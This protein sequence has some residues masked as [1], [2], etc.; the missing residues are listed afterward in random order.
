[1]LSQLLEWC[2]AKQHAGATQ[3]IRRA[4]ALQIDAGISAPWQ[5]ALEVRDTGDGRGR[6]VFALRAFGRDDIVEVCPVVLA[7]GSL[8]EPLSQRVFDWR[9]LARS[10]HD[11]AL[12]LGFGSLYNHNDDANCRYF[13]ERDHL[14]ICA[15]RGIAPSAELT[16]NYN[17]RGGGPA[18]PRNKWFEG[19]DIQKI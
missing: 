6:G 8:P 3:A 9:H 15:V 12:A 5:A 18:W 11:H 10:K 17:S 4:H 1:M 7:T 14:V 19:H 16:I 13:A 2:L